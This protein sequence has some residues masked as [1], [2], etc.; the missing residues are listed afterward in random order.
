MVRYHTPAIV[1]ELRLLAIAKE[2]FAAAAQQTW[3]AYAR[4]NATCSKLTFA[5][6]QAHVPGA[7]CRRLPP[8]SVGAYA[9]LLQPLVL[10][11]SSALVH[12][13]ASL[14]C[15]F[16]LARLS[17]Q[18]GWVRPQ[19][20]EPAADG[21]QLLEITAGRNPIVE[22]ALQRAGG[23]RSFIPN[24]T[25]MNAA[26]ERCALITGPNMGGKSC[27]IRQVALLVVLAQMGRCVPACVS[28]AIP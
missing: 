28:F 20:E 18:A 23:G 15:L 6:L 10:H 27:Y 16:A 21:Q 3:Y 8:V 7:V 11:C 9:F 24:N 12:K 19:V 4:D 1:E 14:D 13:L 26:G 22:A 2:R 25:R 5:L 17:Q